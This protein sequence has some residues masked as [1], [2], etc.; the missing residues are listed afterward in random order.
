MNRKKLS[1]NDLVLL[2]IVRGFTAPLSSN[3]RPGRRLPVRWLRT[4]I[5]ISDNDVSHRVPHSPNRE[6]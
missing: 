5:A 4:V 3:E 6:A 2:L 1:H